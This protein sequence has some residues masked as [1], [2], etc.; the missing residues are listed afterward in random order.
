MKG[1]KVLGTKELDR[2]RNRAGRQYGLGRIS[3]ED[4]EFLSH[5]MDE[6]QVRIDVM[7]EQDDGADEAEG[8]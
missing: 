2:L 1:L 5:H 4:F 7:E 6:I 3:R 8:D